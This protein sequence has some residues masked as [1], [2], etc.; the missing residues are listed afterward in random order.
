MNPDCIKLEDIPTQPFRPLGKTGRE[1]RTNKAT[2]DAQR[3]RILIEDG[4]TA[5]LKQS[6]GWQN[7]S[8]P[9][10]VDSLTIENK[11]ATNYSDWNYRTFKNYYKDTTSNYKIIVGEFYLC[12]TAFNTNG[13]SRDTDFYNL[14]QYIPPFG[15]SGYSAIGNWS[16]VSAQLINGTFNYSKYK[17]LPSDY[18]QN[19]YGICGVMS[20]SFVIDVNNITNASRRNKPITYGRVLSAFYQKGKIIIKYYG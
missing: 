12:F 5:E 6:R 14:L 3:V 10:R 16:G 17:Q 2:V 1:P 8:T 13:W 9:T 19:R 15:A 7:F 11:F 20:G 18:T 4:N